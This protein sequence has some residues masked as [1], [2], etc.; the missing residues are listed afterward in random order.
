MSTKTL[1]KR[2]ALVAVSALGLGLMSVAPA[3]ASNSYSSNITL[4]TSS[5]TV[6]GTS[7][8]VANA[9][10]FYVDVTTADTTTATAPAPA[11]LRADESITAWISA[12]P[13][14]GFTTGNVS[15]VAGQLSAQNTFAATLAPVGA[16]LAATTTSASAFQVPNAG[17]AA[18]FS[19]SNWSHS[20]TAASNNERNR[21]WFAVYPTSTGVINAGEF[22]LTVR[23]NNTTTNG[24]GTVDKTIKVKFVSDIA[25]AGATLTVAQTGNITNGAAYAFTPTT[26]TVATL[27]D[28]NGGRVVLGTAANGTILPSAWT[29]TMTANVI[30]STGIIGESLTVSDAGVTAQDYVA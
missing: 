10:W 21:Y 24:R 23:L 26:S 14:T 5:L 19:S 1:R 22:T 17:T 8:S 30:G 11:A 29:P 9:G 7:A 13:A 4:S 15:L 27:K 20:T 3:Q 18:S 12:S 16:A 6:V 2:I 28:A 25:D